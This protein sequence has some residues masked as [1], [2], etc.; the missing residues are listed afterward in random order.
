MGINYGQL[1]KKKVKIKY[2]LGKGAPNKL[3]AFLS[4]NP[5]II[6][7]MKDDNI[8][9]KLEK[10]IKKA[11]LTQMKLANIYNQVNYLDLLFATL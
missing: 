4:N 11:L 2:F 3:K 5:Q 8:V 10:K 9:Y 6:L 1:R 7:L